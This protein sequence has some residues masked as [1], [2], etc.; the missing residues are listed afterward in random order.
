MLRPMARRATRKPERTA[1]RL[2]RTTGTLTPLSHSA[3]EHSS[4]G[5]DKMEAAPGGWQ[6]NESAAD[7][8]YQ[9]AIDAAR[10]AA[11]CEKTF[12][13]QRRTLAKAVYS[14]IIAVMPLD[15]L[16]A[17][18]RRMGD[19]EKRIL[20]PSNIVSYLQAKG[21]PVPHLGAS[22]PFLGIFHRFYQNGRTEQK[23]ISADEA[24]EI[25]DAA[26]EGM[27]RNS[28]PQQHGAPLCAA[29]LAAIDM[30]DP[31]LL[32]KGIHAVTK[33]Y[34]AFRRT[35]RTLAVPARTGSHER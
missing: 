12:H 6:F 8:A 5:T 16:E 19:T 34:M 20:L 2:D 9:A 25:V 35:Q 1:T 14:F 11:I 15:E 33:V 23:L 13:Q 4:I 26:N 18:K 27:I 30:K 10:A 29:G 32:D 7:T 17:L 28:G 31:E 22:N 21:L 3:I 24:Q